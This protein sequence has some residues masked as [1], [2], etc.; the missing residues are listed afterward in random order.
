MIIFVRGKLTLFQNI[1][2]ACNRLN[3]KYVNS[4]KRTGKLLTAQ[5]L[6]GLYCVFLRSSSSIWTSEICRN[7]QLSD[8]TR[9]EN[10][11]KV[12]SFADSP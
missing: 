7:H 3:Y 8:K 1:F 4:L 11:S 12:H 9:L 2:R 6:P 10:I 5:M